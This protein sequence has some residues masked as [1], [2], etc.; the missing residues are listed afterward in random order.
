MALPD[1]NDQTVEQRHEFIR[2]HGTSAATDSQHHH[3]EAAARVGSDLRTIPTGAHHNGRTS[4]S[5]RSD[6]ELTQP[7]DDF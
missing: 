2:R 5:L 7:D 4:E 1:R 6:Q 3:I